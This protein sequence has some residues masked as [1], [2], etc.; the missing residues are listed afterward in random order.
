MGYNNNSVDVYPF[1]RPFA[2]PAMAQL[3][4][5]MQSQDDENK[6]LRDVLENFAKNTSTYDNLE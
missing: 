1:S 3:A 6:K 4:A 2:D 5:M